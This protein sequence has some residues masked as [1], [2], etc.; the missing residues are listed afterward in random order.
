MLDRKLCFFG[1][2]IPNPKHEIRNNDK[3]TNVPMTKKRIF[4]VLVWV[5]LSFDIRICFGFRISIFGFCLNGFFVQTLSSSP[6]LNGSEDRHI[7]RE[8]NIRLAENA[9]KTMSNPFG[10]KL[11]MDGINRS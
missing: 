9:L 5:I 8:A 3:N 11:L 2:E 7:V 6:K 10:K 1:Q 4:M